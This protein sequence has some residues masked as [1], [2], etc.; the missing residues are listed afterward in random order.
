[1]QSVVREVCVRSFRKKRKWHLP[2][3]MCVWVKFTQGWHSS[4]VLQDE[5]ESFSS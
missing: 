5:E 4:R 3:W 2:Q 1:M